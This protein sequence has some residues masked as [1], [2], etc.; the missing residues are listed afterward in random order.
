[1]RIALT[2]VKFSSTTKTN[3][4]VFLEVCEFEIVYYPNIHSTVT[5]TLL[6][7]LLKFIVLVLTERHC[8]VLTD[9]SLGD[10]GSPKIHS[11]SP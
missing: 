7:E 3:F 4:Q 5:L 1:M 9:S 10:M 6:I 8:M 2:S 11:A